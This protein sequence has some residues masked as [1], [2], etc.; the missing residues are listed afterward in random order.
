MP[1]TNEQLLTMPVDVLIPAALGGVFDRE[2]AK[3]VQAQVIVE[4]ANGPTWPEADEV[5]V[6]RGIP[7]VPDVLANAGGVIVSYFEWVQN[8]QHFRWPLEQ[9]QREEERRLVEAFRDMYDLA[10]RKRRHPPHG[11]VHEGDLAGR[12][13]QDPGRDVRPSALARH[14][15]RSSLDRIPAA[16]ASQAAAAC[17]WACAGSGCRG[18]WRGGPWRPASCRPASA[19]C[20]SCDVASWPSWI[21][22]LLG[23]FDETRS[24]VGRPGGQRVLL[25]GR[26]RL[27]SS[28]AVG[29]STGS[30]ADL[31][32]R[33]IGDL[34]YL[35]MRWSKSS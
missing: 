22:V 13:G 29:A 18:S 32:L 5:F 10:Q 4:A 33:Q 15:D 16:A 31:A 35:M 11:G 24:V 14:L 27:R 23:E 28:R 9:I 34:S 6:A 8:L 19:T 20:S 25:C 1:T 17:A 12:P 26:G 3:A 7:V 30:I 2:M 21:F